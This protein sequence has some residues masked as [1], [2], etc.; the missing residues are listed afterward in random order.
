MASLQTCLR[1]STIVMVLMC[2][3][4]SWFKHRRAEPV[5]AADAPAAGLAIA[6]PAPLPPDAAALAQATGL[7]TDFYEMRLRLGKSGLPDEAE[8]K[9]YRAFLCPALAG[10]MDVARSR[11]QEYASTHPDEK[12][13]LVEGDLFSSLVEGPDAVSAAGTEVEGEGARVTLAMRAGD[14]D[15]APHWK[16]DLLLE[17]HDGIWC[18]ADVDYRGDWPFANKG[19]LSETLAAP[20]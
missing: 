1:T 12:P 19:K 4:C 3:G 17:R 18:I 5:P 14:G 16:D 7:A 11:Q 6:A 13:P 2:C 15:D 10:L 9:A 20:F 8:M